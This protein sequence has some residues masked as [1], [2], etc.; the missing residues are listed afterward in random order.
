MTSTTGL[1]EGLTTVTEGEAVPILWRHSETVTATAGLLEAATACRRLPIEAAR[2]RLLMPYSTLGARS[3]VRMLTAPNSTHVR[4]VLDVL[5][6]DCRRR[7]EPDLL[8]R[9]DGKLP[10]GT[11]RRETSQVWAYWADAA[12]GG[13]G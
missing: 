5:G 1:Q 7:G 2:L 13:E 8:V 9:I 6:V 3:G 4:N 11:R 12:Q 10:E